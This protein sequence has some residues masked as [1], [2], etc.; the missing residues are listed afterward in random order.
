MWNPKSDHRRTGLI[1]AGSVLAVA[2]VIGAGVLAARSRG[3]AVDSYPTYAGKPPQPA[4][5]TGPAGGRP[6]ATHRPDPPRHRP[7]APNP[8]ALRPGEPVTAAR[9]A[10]VNPERFFY[11]VM[12]RQAMVQITDLTSE[13]FDSPQERLHRDRYDNTVTR[14]IID[15][16]HRRVTEASSYGVPANADISRCINGTSKNFSRISH[17]WGPGIFDYACTHLDDHNFQSTDGIT[18]GGLTAPQAD[19]YTA[20]LQALRGFINPRQPRLLIDHGHRYIRMVVD[21]RPILGSR[22]AYLGAL[23]LFDQAFKD[24]G[25]YTTPRIFLTSTAP[26]Q[27]IHCIY[28]ID[29]VT[30]RPSFSKLLGTTVVNADGRPAH[31]FPNSHVYQYRYPARLPVFT[32]QD[33]Q[34]VVL[35]PPEGMRID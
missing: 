14:R 33:H 26:G 6:T 34:P 19:R 31:P 35:D 4:G 29:P 28:Y 20:R 13:H 10:H 3:S 7:P 32:M 11:E 16:P 2:A 12:K 5:T 18:P 17:T 22:G 23:Q 21:I 25:L 24:A 27:G 30:L 8:P 9:L 1:V 15:Y